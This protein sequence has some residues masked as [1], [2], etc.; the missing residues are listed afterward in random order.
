MRAVLDV[1]THVVMGVAVDVLDALVANKKGSKNWL[2]LI[3]V[4]LYI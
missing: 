1:R 4:L 3:I 2:C